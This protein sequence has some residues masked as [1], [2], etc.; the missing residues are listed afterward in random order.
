MI[1]QTAC[2]VF[3]QVCGLF[4][5]YEYFAIFYILKNKFG[6]LSNSNNEVASYHAGQIKA[7]EKSLEKMLESYEKMKALEG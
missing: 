5:R 4:C 7:A 3:P 1:F 6:D 2:R